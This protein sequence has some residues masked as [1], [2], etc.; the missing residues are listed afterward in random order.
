MIYVDRKCVDL[1]DQDIAG[2]VLEPHVVQKTGHLLTELGRI[3]LAV[4]LTPHQR[5]L[6][7]NCKLS[8]KPKA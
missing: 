6:A 2:D 3:L 8:A 1:L 4:V 7:L 5:G